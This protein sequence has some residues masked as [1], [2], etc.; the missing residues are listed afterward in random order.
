[1]HLC[2]LQQ[3]V[4]N[5]VWLPPCDSFAVTSYSTESVEASVETAGRVFVLAGLSIA[6]TSFPNFLF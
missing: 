2:C 4:T 6:E 5:C 3:V 1:M